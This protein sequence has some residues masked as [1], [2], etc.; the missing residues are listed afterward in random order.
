MNR[1][2]SHRRLAKRMM[3]WPLR[4]GGVKRLSVDRTAEMVAHHFIVEGS[5]HCWGAGII[6]DQVDLDEIVQVLN[7]YYL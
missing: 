3:T 5:A 7:L 4:K 6:F 1:S 2:A